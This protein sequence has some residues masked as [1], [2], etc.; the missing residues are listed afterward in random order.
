[1]RRKT[2]ER[3]NQG[4]LVFIPLVTMVIILPFLAGAH[5]RFPSARAEIC[6]ALSWTPWR[7]CVSRQEIG[8]TIL[9]LIVLMKRGRS[10]STTPS[11]LEW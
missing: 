10:I 8:P 6:C 2:P 7:K 3:I 9:G 11:R 4:L 5:P 1:M